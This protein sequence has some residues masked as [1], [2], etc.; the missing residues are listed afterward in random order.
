[1]KKAQKIILLLA[2]IVPFFTIVSCGSLLPSLIFNP[3]VV[4]SFQNAMEEITPEQEYYIGRAVAANLLSTYKLWNGSPALLSYLN[5]ICGAITVN[6]P[7]P[8]VYNGYHVAILDT[9]EINAFATPGGHIFVSRGLINVAKSEEALAGVIAH[10]VS[11]I[12]LKHSI[13]AIKSSRFTNALRVT[14]SAA[15]AQLAQG[16]VFS[17]LVDTF[18]ESVGD[19]VSTMVNSGYSQTQ[20]FEADNMAMKLMAAAG[21]NPSGLIAMLQELEKIQ[22]SHPGGFNK[23]HPTPAAR[24]RNAQRTLNTYR[25]TDTSS[26][27]QA[28]FSALR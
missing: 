25:V 18:S 2:V 16:T 11:H 23:T 7:R 6:S 4:G 28:R 22:S 21:Y 19:V 13:N 14:G 24:I 5:R 12:Q 20:E 26:F 15:A 17:E 3:E 1:M 10:E 8:D 9:D 27:R